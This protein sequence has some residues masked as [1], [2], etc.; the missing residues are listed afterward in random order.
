MICFLHPDFFDDTCK[1]C[2]KEY[3]EMKGITN[4]QE[5]FV[6]VKKYKELTEDRAKRL[7]EEIVLQYLKSGLTDLESVE[8]AKAVLRRQCAIRGMKDWPWL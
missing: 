7:F 4:K 2:R 5:R 1:E 8:K 6:V 3:L